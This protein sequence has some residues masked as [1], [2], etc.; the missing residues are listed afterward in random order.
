MVHLT[1]ATQQNTKSRH[2]AFRLFGTLSLSTVARVYQTICIAIHQND[3]SQI[4]F[5]R[6]NK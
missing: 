4:I 5:G 2:D 6:K 3:S 1:R